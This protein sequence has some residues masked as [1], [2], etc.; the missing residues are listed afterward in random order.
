MNGDTVDAMDS[1]RD[2]WNAMQRIVARLMQW[3]VAEMDGMRCNG[4]LRLCKIMFFLFVLHAEC[5][6]TTPD[7]S[8]FVLSVKFCDQE[9]GSNLH[10]RERNK[11]F[12]MLQLLN[13][14]AAQCHIHVLVLLFVVF[15][16][17]PFVMFSFLSCSLWRCIYHYQSWYS[18]ACHPHHTSTSFTIMR[19]QCSFDGCDN[20][21]TKY[22]NERCRTHGGRTK[23]NHLGCDS[24]A[25]KVASVGV[26]NLI[27]YFAAQQVAPANP[28]RMEFARYMV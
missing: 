12:S 16:L 6:L 10:T 21:P 8:A 1:S 17:A 13:A 14:P 2:G 22:G 27:K 3:T 7:P 26:I 4:L 11:R 20:R 9:T 18:C 15:S 5:E 19:N 24:F 25:Q 23:C 28:K